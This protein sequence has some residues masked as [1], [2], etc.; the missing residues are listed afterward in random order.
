MNSTLASN[1]ILTL[2]YPGSTHQGTWR[3]FR[4]GSRCFEASRDLCDSE[5]APGYVD[6]RVIT[7]PEDLACFVKNLLFYGWS[8]AF[9][10]EQEKSFWDQCLPQVAKS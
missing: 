2:T 5:S 9:L 6:R 8:I 10:P 1:D 3:L 7:T 4:C